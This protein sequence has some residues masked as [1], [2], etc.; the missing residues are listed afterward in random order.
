MGAS[1]CNILPNA[2]EMYIEQGVYALS[3]LSQVE[4]A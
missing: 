4:I 1:K 3:S 2:V